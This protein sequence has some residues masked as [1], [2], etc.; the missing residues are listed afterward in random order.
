M[1]RADNDALEAKPQIA[2]LARALYKEELEKNGRYLTNEAV[3]RSFKNLMDH[4][5][6]PYLAKAAT[7]LKDYQ[8]IHQMLQE[9]FDLN[10]IKMETR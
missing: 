10:D 6:Y 4:H 1:S 3:V 7:F 8:K 2:V 9:Q 5:Q